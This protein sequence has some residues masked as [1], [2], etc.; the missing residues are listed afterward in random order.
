VLLRELLLENVEVGSCLFGLFTVA[1][2]PLQV[3]ASHRSSGGGG[4]GAG[5]RAGNDAPRAR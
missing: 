5:S 3:T 1:S 4:G 2:S